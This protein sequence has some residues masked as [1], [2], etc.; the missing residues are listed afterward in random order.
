MKKLIVGGVP[1]HYNLPWH[2]ALEHPNS[3]INQSFEWKSFPAGT[4]AMVKELRESS[5]D[6]AVLLTE[7]IIAD[8]EAGNDARIIQFFVSSPLRWGIHVAAHSHFSQPNLLNGAQYAISRFKSGSHLMPFVHAERNQMT[9]HEHDF[10]LVENLE[11]ARKAMAQNPNL[12]FFWERFTTK[13]LVDS[14]ELKYLGDCFTPWPS[15]AIAARSEIIRQHPE[16]LSSLINSINLLTKQLSHR[17]DII[18]ILSTK[19]KLNQ[20]DAQEWFSALTWTAN[21][22]DAINLEKI[23]YDLA[24]FGITKQPL[25]PEN[26]FSPL[27]LPEVSTNESW[28]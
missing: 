26:V 10:V 22:P 12:V 5:I 7:G 2:W 6:V 20:Q 11:G 17:S 4:G 27:T 14:G 28:F 15:F 16:S 8:I 1:E 13:H 3:H 21:S 24:H 19:Y 18:Q 23:L 25:L 9:I